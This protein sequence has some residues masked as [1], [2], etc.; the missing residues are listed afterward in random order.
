MTWGTYISHMAILSKNYSKNIFNPKDEDMVNLW[1]KMLEH[2]EDETFIKAIKKIMLNE[3]FAPNLATISKYCSEIEA[4]VMDDAEGWGIVVKAINTY[5]YMRPKEAMDS[6]PPTVR[7]A[8]EYMGGFKII[9][10]SE[11][12]DVTRGQFNKCMATLNQRERAE[13]REKNGLMQAVSLMN[14]EEETLQIE[15]KEWNRS[16]ED[17]VNEGLAK[18]HEVLRKAKENRYEETNAK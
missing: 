13:R 15:Y 1:F 6:L 11:N 16:S 9:C 12:P 10:E 8:V 2:Y 17:V 3:I 7:K 18:V 5:G 4:P 14:S